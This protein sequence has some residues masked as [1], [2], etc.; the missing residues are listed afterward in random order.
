MNVSLK[1]ELAAFIDRQVREGRFATADEAINAAV[2]RLQF[3]ENEES[4]WDIDELRAEIDLGLA[5]LDAGRIVD[6]T[7]ED[8]IRECNAAFKAKQHGGITKNRE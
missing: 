5:D 1:P 2:A 7:A 8:V 6:F 3:E 4:D